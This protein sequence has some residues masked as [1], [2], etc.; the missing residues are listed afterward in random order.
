VL[1]KEC[2]FSSLSV[3]SLNGNNNIR[4]IYRIRD[5]VTTILLSWSIM[6]GLAYRKQDIVVFSILYGIKIIWCALYAKLLSFIPYDRQKLIH[7]RYFLIFPFEPLNNIF[8]C[9][10]IRPLR[11]N[12]HAY[13]RL[14]RLKLFMSLNCVLCRYDLRAYK[15]IL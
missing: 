12:S 10:C 5:C 1:L 6:S 4:T 9:I 11:T 8:S 7:V 15:S 14:N 13:V 2:I 3:P